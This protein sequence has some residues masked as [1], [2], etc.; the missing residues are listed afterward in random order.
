MA[1]AG[2]VPG[3]QGD[4]GAFA[5]L[6]RD[7]LKMYMQAIGQSQPPMPAGPGPMPTPVPSPSGY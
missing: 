5:S 2:P 6:L 3:P 4:L 7:A 1:P